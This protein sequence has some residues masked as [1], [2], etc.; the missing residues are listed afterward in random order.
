MRYDEI[1]SVL[2]NLCLFASIF[3]TDDE[4]QSGTTI[5]HFF[6]QHTRL[7]ISEVVLGVD[8]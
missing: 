4:E 1:D 8:F 2:P 6:L 3:R 7:H 5:Y